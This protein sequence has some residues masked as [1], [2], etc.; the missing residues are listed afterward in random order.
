MTLRPATVDEVREMVVEHAG[1]RVPLR[2]AARGT[3]LDAG[4]PVEGATRLDVSALSGVVEY[5]PGDLTLTARAGTPLGE[6]TALTRANGQFLPLDPWGGDDGSLGATIATATAGP[7]A[8]GGSG[9]RGLPRDV[10]LG[11]EFVDGRGRVARGGGRVVKNVAGFD[12]VRMQTGAWGTLGVLT[13]VSVRLSALPERDE[14]VALATGG[15]PASFDA[16]LASLRER[17]WSAAACELVNGNLAKRLGVGDA[18]MALVRLAGNDAAVRAM[19]AIV[20]GLGDTRDVPA[21]VWD[22]LRR[23]D[24][25]AQVVVRFSAPPA[26]LGGVWRAAATL[27]HEQGDMHASV[28]RGVVRC[29]LADV[30]ADALHRVRR[31]LNAGYVFERL[32]ATRWNDGHTAPA[33]PS[34]RLGTALLDAFDP[35]RVLNRGIIHPGPA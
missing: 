35:A 30:D 33:A 14:T 34:G 32:D 12:L 5:T 22:A 21:S 25:G 1:R 28:A 16:T 8:G 31:G 23:S 10:V 2:I 27:S 4:R 9:G 26:S 3:W 13:E 7:R 15:D 20:S 29:L 19:R 18:P 11:V 6:L 24:R 17:A